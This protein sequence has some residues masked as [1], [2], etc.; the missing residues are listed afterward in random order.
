MPAEFTGVV[1]AGGRSLRMG[2]DKALLPWGCGTLLDRMV[3][4]LRDAGATRVL[5]SGDRPGYDAVADE[6]PGRGPVGG[7]QAVMACVEGPLVVVPVDLPRL[8][9]DRLHVLRDAL[10]SASAAS[11]AGQ[12]LPFALVA[13]AMSRA[14]VAGIMAAHPAGAPVRQL[15]DA[16]GAAV[17]PLDGPYDD[18]APCNT[19][20]DWEALAG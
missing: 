3:G 2:R 1:L 12:P 20:A 4:R 15:L 6:V 5:V 7:L 10:D 17:L 18:L 9:M 14:T 13:D 11:F 16:L 19:P 8:R